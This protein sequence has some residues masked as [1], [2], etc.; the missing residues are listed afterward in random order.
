MKKTVIFFYVSLLIIITAFFSFLLLQKGEKLK[1]SYLIQNSNNLYNLEKH[2][3]LYQGILNTQLKSNQFDYEV[4]HYETDSEFETLLDQIVKS[5]ASNVLFFDFE[6]KETYDTF[7]KINTYS[8]PLFFT[9]FESKELKQNEEKDILYLFPP[10]EVIAEA[11]NHLFN[12]NNNQNILLI[13]SQKNQLRNSVFQ[14]QLKGQKTTVSILEEKEFQNSVK[15]I[16]D[17]LSKVNPDYILIDLSEKSTITILEKIVGFPRNQIILMLENT[18]NNVAYYTGSTSY[19]VN[20]ITFFNPSQEND[21]DNKT[22]LLKIITQTLAR[23][24]KEEK[25]IDINT[26]NNFIEKNPNIPFRL[27]NHS[28]YT[29]IYRVA[30]TDEGL[31]VI[32]KFELKK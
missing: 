16:G 5:R 7:M 18:S 1:I 11:L 17:I 4:I 24:F 15:N 8:A 14:K 12:L 28:I 9:S 31:R 32:D 19:G 10:S 13:N 20:G 26:F 23:C 6:K 30:F 3:L 27:K 21:F 29:P 22:S 2:G 25:K